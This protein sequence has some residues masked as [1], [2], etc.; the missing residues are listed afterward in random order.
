M[1]MISVMLVGYDGSYGDFIQ[2]QVITYK[3]IQYMAIIAGLILV[4]SGSLISWFV[5]LYGSFKIAG[6]LYRFVKNLEHCQQ[7]EK[8][9]SLR[10][11]DDLQDLSYKI[12]E[13]AQTS[14]NHSLELLNE[15]NYYLELTSL[16]DDKQNRQE[17]IT[18]V[19]R[20]QKIE[21][22]AKVND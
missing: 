10:S 2:S 21:N 18:V 19:K 6:P 15:I 13:A 12:I 22:R 7:S 4:L 11:G 3:N 1:A 9:Q 20:I 16:A 14:E 17:I 8:M 5:A